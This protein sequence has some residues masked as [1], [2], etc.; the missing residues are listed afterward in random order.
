MVVALNVL[1]DLRKDF[2]RLLP[3]KGAISRLVELHDLLYNN[4]S[5]FLKK[6]RLKHQLRLP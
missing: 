2:D 5:F 4:F 1:V 3:D 6:I